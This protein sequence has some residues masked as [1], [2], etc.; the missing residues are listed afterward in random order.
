[1]PTSSSMSATSSSTTARRRSC[2]AGRNSSTCAS[3]YGSMG[4]VML[5]EVPLVADVGY[6]LDDLIA[7]VEQL[8]TPSLRQKA[9][10]ARRRGAASSASAAKTLRAQVVEQSGLGPEPAHRRSR[11]LGGRASSPIPTPSSCTRPARCICT[12]ST[13]IR[14]AAASCSSTTA[15]ISARASAPRPA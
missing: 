5:T 9:R 3:T 15:P 7:A 14:S 2:R 13:S 10:R 6:G 1:M 8:M 11:D 4:N 12:A